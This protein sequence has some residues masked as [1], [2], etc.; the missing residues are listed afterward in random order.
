M[1]HDADESVFEIRRPSDGD[2]GREHVKPGRLKT[3]G[4]DGRMSWWE[5]RYLVLR[6]PCLSNGRLHRVNLITLSMRV[7]IAG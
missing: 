4:S 2:H 1:V 3:K 5:G 7:Q 6:I